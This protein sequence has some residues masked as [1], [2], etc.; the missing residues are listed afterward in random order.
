MKQD[1]REKRI[2]TQ[3]RKDNYLLNKRTRYSFAWGREKISLIIPGDSPFGPG[4]AF[5]RIDAMA[6]STSLLVITSSSGESRFHA[7]SGSQSGIK[8]P[9]SRH[10]T[11]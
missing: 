6:A 4:A 7:K 8:H 3:S 11:R 1:E 10:D 2:L 5:S 9:V